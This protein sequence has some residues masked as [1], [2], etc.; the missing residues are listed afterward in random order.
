LPR[1]PPFSALFASRRREADSI[2]EPTEFAIL[3]RVAA[4]EACPVQNPP[5][6]AGSASF[7]Q[8][9]HGDAKH[10]DVARRGIGGCK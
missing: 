2:E 1:G 6:R 5:C 7:E 10:L 9:S 8:P 3:R 4:E